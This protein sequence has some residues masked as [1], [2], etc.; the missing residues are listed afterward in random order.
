VVALV[1]AKLKED[2]PPVRSLNPSAPQEIA[3]L[4]DRMVKRDPAE[5]PAALGEVV[6]VLTDYQDREEGQLGPA[7][8]RITER[9]KKLP[10]FPQ[11]GFALLK[12][13]SRENTNVDRLQRIISA[14]SVLVARILRVVNSAY[15]SIPNRVSTIKHAVSM[16]GFRQVRD[17]AFGIY[18]LELGRG[19]K[20]GGIGHPL[21][22]RYW[23]HS[24][25]VAFLSEALARFLALPTVHPGE[26]YVAGLLHDIG[27]LILTRYEVQKTTEAV[28]IQSERKCPSDEVERELIGTTHCELAEWLAQKWSLPEHLHSVAVH[29][30]LARPQS[31]T[32]ELETTVR[33]A[34]A[35]AVRNGYGF[36]LADDGW[37]LERP[38]HRILMMSNS[39]VPESDLLPF[40]EELLADILH[41]LNVYMSAFSGKPLTAPSLRSPSFSTSL[42]EASRGSHQRPRKPG[43]FHG[44]RRWL[45]S[46]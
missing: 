45:E 19:F 31:P 34:D 41:Q 39:K 24:V 30:H 15:Y 22:L 42:P 32:A 26:A 2:A 1:K 11:V 40:L 6:K 17:L 20:G 25:A 12:E 27:L 35:I 16:L 43:I 8:T 33:L 28:K 14:D 29:H 13:M 21:Q 7:A 44:F 46:I 4:V 18:L 10:P 9:I 38:L 5:R 37:E 23:S 36:Y 3:G